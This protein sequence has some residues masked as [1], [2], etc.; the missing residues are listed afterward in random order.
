[1]SFDDTEIP[2]QSPSMVI[3]H[4]TSVDTEKETF[5]K[6]NDIDSVVDTESTSEKGV[7]PGKR[8]IILGMIVCLVVLMNTVYALTRRSYQEVTSN[9]TV[10]FG[11]NDP[12][13]IPESEAKLEPN[14]FNFPEFNVGVASCVFDFNLYEKQIVC[15]QDLLPKTSDVISKLVEGNCTDMSLPEPLGISLKSNNN[16]GVAKT[17]ISFNGIPEIA[18]G[19][20]ISMQF[21]LLTTVIYSGMDM[22][23]EKT[24]IIAT[25]GYEGGIGNTGYTVTETESNNSQ[26]HPGAI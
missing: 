20:R 5:L 17:E 19:E 15:T 25:F 1:M 24:P 16:D 3:A 12:A 23:F 21:C 7:L 13:P 4:R 26:P 18:N 14:P 9:P 22:D 6:D 10:G 2:N 8:R 11:F